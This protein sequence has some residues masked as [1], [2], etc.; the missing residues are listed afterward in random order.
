MIKFLI[1]G[2]IRD[3]TRSKFP[4]AI[5][6]IGVFFTI[7]LSAFIGGVLQDAVEVNARFTTGHV[8]VSTLAFAENSTQ[9]PLDLALLGMDSIKS[10]LQNEYPKMMWVPRVS[11]GGLLDVPDENGETKGQGPCTGMA[12]DLLNTENGELERMNINKTIVEGRAPEK[13]GEA[14]VSEKFAQKMKLKPGDVVTYFGSTMYGSMCF[15]NFTICGTISFGQQM[16]DKGGLII[17]I[18]DAQQMLDMEDGS[19]E[20]LGY[21]EGGQYLDDEAMKIA[22]EFNARSTDSTDEFSSVM[23]PLKKQNQL[24]GLLNTSESMSEIMVGIFVLAMSIVLWNVGLLGG[25]RRYKEFGV[26]LALGEAKGKIYRSLL[27]EATVI[28]VVGSVFG[29]ILGLAAAIPL[30]IYG[31]DVSEMVPSSNMM[32]PSVYRAAVTPSTVFMGF[33]PGIIAMVLGQA[34]AGYGIYKRDTARL[35]K[36]LEV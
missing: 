29:V 11:F 2:V 9:A 3:S 17:D 16:L 19:T 7:F 14:L 35:F 27:V 24:E 18:S 13:R 8:K 12:A 30:Q 34:L 25:L 33:I 20:L 26:R 4:I 10:G 21:F 6:A 23:I 36:E 15:Q 1:K 28:G 32:M 22:Q 5:V 31:M